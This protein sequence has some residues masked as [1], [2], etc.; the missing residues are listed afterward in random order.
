MLNKKLMINLVKDFLT[1]DLP[2]NYVYHNLEHTKYVVKKCIEIG[3]Q[4][5]C[6]ANEL[7]LLEIA[8]WW[9]DVGFIYRNVG[10]E[11][12]SCL[13][14]IKHLPNFQFNT[15][16]IDIICGMIMATKIPQSPKT[17]LEEILAD[18]DL[19]YIGTNDVTKFA[20]RLYLELKFAH[21]NLTIEEWDRVQIKFL[22]HHQYFTSYCKKTI[23]ENKLQYLQK[24]KILYSSPTEH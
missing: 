2:P 20:N 5:K 7:H 15:E 8:A 24:L 21:P 22:Q 1:K 13:L 10:H 18:A 11:K 19:I 12:E 3:K 4:E 6:N 16:E 23:T 17:H 14:A 9:H